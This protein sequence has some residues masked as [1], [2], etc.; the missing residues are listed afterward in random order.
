MSMCYIAYTSDGE[1]S[2]AYLHYAQ[3]IL[4]WA[5]YHRDVAED[6]KHDLEQ[7]IDDGWMKDYATKQVDFHEKA[8][9]YFNSDNA[10]LGGCEKDAGMRG[11]WQVNSPWAAKAWMEL[12]ETYQN[13]PCPMPSSRPCHINFDTKTITVKENNPYCRWDKYAPDG[14]TTVLI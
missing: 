9:E 3:A 5:K 6:W 12:A 7:G 10:D 2:E 14:W 4:D 11:F 8:A 1:T 13:G